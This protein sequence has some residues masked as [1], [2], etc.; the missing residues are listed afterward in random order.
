MSLLY[1]KLAETFKILEQFKVLKLI[2]RIMVRW[3]R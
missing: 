2:S 1:G 3:E